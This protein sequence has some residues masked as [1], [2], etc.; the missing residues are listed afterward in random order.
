MSAARAW[1]EGFPE[2]FRWD[3]LCT[4]DALC[5][6]RMRLYGCHLPQ[7]VERARYGKAPR[8]HFGTL[9]E[10][11]LLSCCG[12]G[13]RPQPPPRHEICTFYPES[14]PAT[15]SDFKAPPPSLSPARALME[16][17]PHTCQGLDGLE[18]S[19]VW[20]ASAWEQQSLQA[21]ALEMHSC[22]PF[23]GLAM[24]RIKAH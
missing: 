20:K 10:R 16:G 14:A 5:M 7:V 12:G 8:P 24:A 1:T 21:C 23:E 15:K 19:T 9:L 17:F 13:L 4:L 6:P 22:P 3:A 11:F 18:I 2:H